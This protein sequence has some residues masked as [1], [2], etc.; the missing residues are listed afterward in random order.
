MHILIP[1]NGADGAHHDAGPAADAFFQA[2]YDVARL[3]VSTNA[4]RNA[5]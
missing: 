3:I 2:D 1:S 5:G 4:A